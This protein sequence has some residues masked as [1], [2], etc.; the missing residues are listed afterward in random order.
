[1][2]QA[3]LN[4]P[5]ILDPQVATKLIIRNAMIDFEGRV[6]VI[7]FDLVDAD[8]KM[9]ARRSVVADGSAVQTWISN[10]ESIV[11]TRLLA[12]LGLTGSVA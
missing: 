3:T 11:Y 7:H 6:L 5:L 9:L 8:G 2:A 1:M 4:A 10:Q 12:K